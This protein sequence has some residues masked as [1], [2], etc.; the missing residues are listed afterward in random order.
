MAPHRSNQGYLWCGF[1]CAKN[2]GNAGGERLVAEA[3][4]LPPN[5]GEDRRALSQ[6]ARVIMW[7]IMYRASVLVSR[8]SRRY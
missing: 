2:H 7:V 6:T 5:L 4:D 8:G 3:V 1:R